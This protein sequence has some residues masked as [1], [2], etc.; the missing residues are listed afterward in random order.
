MHSRTTTDLLTLRTPRV[1]AT[2]SNLSR[3]AEFDVW[4]NSKEMQWT[5]KA[6][7]KG[8]GGLDG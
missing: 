5:H 3:F 7:L 4:M 1:P 8:G 2:L 6:N